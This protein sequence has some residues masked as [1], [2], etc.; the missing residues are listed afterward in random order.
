MDLDSFFTWFF[1]HQHVKPYTHQKRQDWNRDWEFYNQIFAEMSDKIEGLIPYENAN[2]YITTK[3]SLQFHNLPDIK[4]IIDESILGEIMIM[5]ISIYETIADSY[6]HS[7]LLVFDTRRKLQIYFDPASFFADGSISQRMRFTSLV[8]GYS[9][10]SVIQSFDYMTPQAVLQHE[11]SPYKDTCG[12]VCLLV[13]L[14]TAY[15]GSDIGEVVNEFYCWLR[16]DRY[17]ADNLLSNCISW[18]ENMFILRNGEY[19]FP[20]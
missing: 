7:C 8:E 15:I 2:V 5:H 14:A 16:H 6:G 20:M 3:P 13:G 11:N 18:Y 12:V 1:K 4:K 19:E 17:K 9:P 10:W